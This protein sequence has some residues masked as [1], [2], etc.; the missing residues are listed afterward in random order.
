MMKISFAN[1]VMGAVQNAVVVCNGA[2]RNAFMIQI[3][4]QVEPLMDIFQGFV[5]ASVS[6]AGKTLSLLGSSVLRTRAS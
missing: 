6:V 4:P 1:N 3:R 5:T 2:A